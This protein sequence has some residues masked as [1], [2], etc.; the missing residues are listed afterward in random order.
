MSKP[1]DKGLSRYRKKRDPTKTTEPFEAE[2][3]RR[4]GA[5]KRGRFVVH[6]HD[7]SRLHYDLRLEHDGVLL[8]WAIPAGI[9]LD[10]DVKRF[11]AHTEDHPLD[12]ADFEGVIPEPEYGAG[13]V[14]VW[15]LE[16]G[17]PAQSL[18]GH[19]G[20]V[21]S[22]AWSDDGQLAS[23]SLTRKALKSTILSN[24]PRSS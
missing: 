3:A 15:D 7:A 4:G 10:P 6:C 8:S 18:E 11:A 2:P 14:I 9:A 1:R 16:S 23:G 20:D 19:S 5:T 22:V 24:R 17:L 12:Y 13:T 21:H